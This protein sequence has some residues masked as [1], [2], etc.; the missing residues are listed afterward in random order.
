M[1]S[2]RDMPVDFAGIYSGTEPKK[3]W[4]IPDRFIERKMKY[5]GSAAPSD[6]YNPF[7]IICNSV[8]TIDWM[9]LSTISSGFSNYC[10]PT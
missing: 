5:K 8:L 3:L 1:E 10:I 2:V 6:C 4:R 7:Q 9:Q